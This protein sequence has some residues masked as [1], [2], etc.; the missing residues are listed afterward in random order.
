M[1]ADPASMLKHAAVRSLRVDIGAKVYQKLDKIH[2]L[3]TIDRVHQRRPLKTISAID[4][5]SRRFERLPISDERR[6][7]RRRSVGVPYFIQYTFDPRLIPSIYIH[8]KR[9]V[10]DAST[11]GRPDRFLAV[12][13]S[14]Q[15]VT[16]LPSRRAIH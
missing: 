12:G 5:A 1:P 8:R 7:V 3:S 11:N 15:D 10:R 14:H 2:I 4:D 6:D 13:E 9:C 16:S